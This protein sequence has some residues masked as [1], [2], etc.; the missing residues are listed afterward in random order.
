MRSLIRSQSGRGRRSSVVHELGAPGAR[1]EGSRFAGSLSRTERPH[2]STS[3]AFAPTLRTALLPRELLNKRGRRVE[4][5][6]G[7][8][9]SY[10]K[11]D[12]F[13]ADAQMVAYLRERTRCYRKGRR[14]PDTPA[15]EEGCRASE[16]TRQRRN[17]CPLCSPSIQS[18][19]CPKL[20][21]LPRE[22]V[23]VEDGE[24]VVCWARAPQSRSCC[25]RSGACAK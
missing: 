23:L 7:A 4:V 19:W 15:G 5:R 12:S 6:V 10:R 24:R 14:A 1:Y 2:I 16:G 21:A 9:V 3:R 13:E 25:A 20:P 8:Q 11:L 18:S 22:Q 17:I